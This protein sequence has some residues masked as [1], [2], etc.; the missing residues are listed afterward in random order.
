MSI[1]I[2]GS[3]GFLGNKISKLLKKEKKIEISSKSKKNTYKTNIFRKKYK[4]ESWISK[5]GKK[6]TLIILS[7][8][9]SMRF[10]AKNRK[11]ILLF[12]N[13]LENRLFKKVNNEV[14]V[15]FLSS[16]MVFK[17]GKKTFLDYSKRLPKNSYGKSKRKI[18]NKLSKYFS[19]LIILRLPKI[20]SEN[21]KDNTIYSQIIK[22]CRKK[23]ITRLFFNQK[24][25]YM[26]L[27][28]FLVIIKKI[29]R[30]KAIKGTF[31]L[32][33]KYLISSSR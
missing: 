32:P 25:H 17:G 27:K 24:M 33:S 15:I 26:N 2:F 1:I 5:I 18:E 30:K 9:G 6:D 16:D 3:S 10:Y 7:N 12:E 21:L 11:E 29:L 31:N 19:K 14:R 4:H 20:Y 13:Y 22:A 8:P 28:D 23:K